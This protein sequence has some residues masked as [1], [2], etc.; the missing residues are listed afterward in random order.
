MPVGCLVGFVV[1]SLFI[2]NLNYD[3]EA[4]REIGMKHF[5]YY[6]ML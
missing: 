1:P 4:N 6:L 3:D 5:N 2:E